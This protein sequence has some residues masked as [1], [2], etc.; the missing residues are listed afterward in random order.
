MKN[1]LSLPA[2]ELFQDLMAHMKERK[3]VDPYLAS[4]SQTLQYMPL[5]IISL[6]LTIY[7]VRYYDLVNK[8]IQ[9]VIFIH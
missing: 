9:F 6:V 7:S 5:I 2:W 3:I 1:K 8:E 4:L